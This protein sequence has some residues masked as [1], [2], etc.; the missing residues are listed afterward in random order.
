MKHPSDF[1]ES[2]RSWKRRGAFFGV[3]AVSGALLLVG[4]ERA[5]SYF[6]LF[7]ATGAASLQNAPRSAKREAKRNGS[8]SHALAKIDAQTVRAYIARWTKPD[9]IARAGARRAVFINAEVLAR[10][11]PAWRL[12]DD[13]ERGAVSPSTPRIARALQTEKTASFLARN[14][15]EKLASLTR[16][17][18]GAVLNVGGA[19]S[20]SGARQNR[21]LDQFLAQSANRDTLRAREDAFL[22]RRAL[23]AATDLARR[24]AVAE[25]DL[26]VLPPDVA[27]ELLNLRLELLRNLA[28]TP[29]QR[30]ATRVEI[31]AIEAR[32]EAILKQQTNLQAARLR[33]ATVDMPERV[34]REGLQKLESAAQITAQKQAQSRRALALETQARWRRDLE[35]SDALRLVLP[36]VRSVL[37][38][39]TRVS[40]PVSPRAFTTKAD[41]FEPT[42]SAV[43][44]N[45]PLETRTTATGARA[46]IANQL[47]QKARLDAAQWARSCAATL[48]ATWNN[49]RSAPDVT[50]QALQIVF[51][52]T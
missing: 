38:P 20:I 47:R 16:D 15:P 29:A 41:F 45:A 24:G 49:S 33:A 52:A 32:Y 39:E 35:S 14:T 17:F 46:R 27:L 30:A 10:R 43:A 2:R 19:D 31:R 50:N 40:N 28:R 22:A 23:E 36:P 48:G 8:L 34:R 5:I 1:A 44:S 26:P 13:L 7:K 37:R 25:L 4:A 42:P 11:H 3:C 6:S 21:A 18:P 9:E 12:A 51:P